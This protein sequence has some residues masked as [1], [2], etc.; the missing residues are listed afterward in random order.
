[1]R[2]ATK[3]SIWTI[4]RLATLASVL[5]LVSSVNAFARAAGAPKHPRQEPSVRRIPDGDKVEKF[6]GIVSK[7]NADSFTMG[8][9]MGGPQTTVVITPQTDVKT[10]RKGAFRGSKQYGQGYI[11]RGLRLE[12]DGVGNSDGQLVAKRIRF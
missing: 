9:S 3:T 7:R 1:M 10:H 11:L 8:E 4:R 5:V 6:K 12:V 2:N